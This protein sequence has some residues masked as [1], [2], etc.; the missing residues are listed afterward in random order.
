[1]CKN[2]PEALVIG[3]LSSVQNA[4]YTW[5]T[6]LPTWSSTV[7]LA[8]VTAPLRSQPLCP[9]LW[10]WAPILQRWLVLQPGHRH[11]DLWV[12]PASSAKPMQCPFLNMYNQG[13]SLLLQEDGRPGRHFLCSERG[14]LSWTPL[15]GLLSPVVALYRV[16]LASPL[17]LANTV[18]GNLTDV[19]ILHFPDGRY[20]THTGCLCCN[21][22]CG[23]WPNID[24]EKITARNIH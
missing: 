3:T 1:M 13:Q 15:Q 7:G 19:C 8:D 22:T 11:H 2:Y 16:T 17:L 6:V 23:N 12:F 21:M 9:C 24:W 20:R 10:L 5:W 18:P 4:D 14:W